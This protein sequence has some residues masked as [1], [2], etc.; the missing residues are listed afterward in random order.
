MTRNER[1]LFYA[2]LHV[3]L[4][5]YGDARGAARS[6]TVPG[7]TRALSDVARATPIYVIGDSLS[8]VFR[9]RVYL[10]ESDDPARYYVARAKY[11]PGLCAGEFTDDEGALHPAVWASLRSE[12]LVV[13]DERSGP[14][15][16]HRSKER[17]WRQLAAI[18]GRSRSSPL[19]LLTCGS[20]DAACIWQS[21]ADDR[22]CV[23][24][25]SLVEMKTAVERCLRPLE[26][27]L[28]L[29]R[30]WG[31]DRIFVHSVA[32]PQLDDAPI[33]DHFG[34]RVPLRVRKCVLRRIN[35][36]LADVCRRTSSVF[37]DV[38]DYTA[39]A[40]V[41]R[42]EYAHDAFHTN[43]RTA[44]IT[45]K[46]VMRELGTSAASMG[47]QDFE[48]LTREQEDHGPRNDRRDQLSFQR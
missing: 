12:H 14:V 25:L 33:A 10:L 8:L 24:E 2:R 9:D 36:S 42:P 47:L 45:L 40:D 19:I 44:L 4:D 31:L 21:V 28:R 7:A 17:Q 6:L 34:V 16:F 11:C 39:D 23:P 22:G 5:A 15:A 3:E 38:W 13:E 26:R 37:L 43:E 46:R 30:S 27:G 1:D 35:Q 32:A 48:G 29:F 41:L 18:E 20:L